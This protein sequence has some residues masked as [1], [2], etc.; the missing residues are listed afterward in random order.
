MTQDEIIRM[1]REAGFELGTA[2]YGNS[3]TL[4][5]FFNLAFEAGAA[6]ERE[7]P[8]T[9]P[10]NGLLAQEPSRSSPTDSQS[11]EIVP[12]GYVDAMFQFQTCQEHHVSPSDRF[13]PVYTAEQ[14][15]AAVLAEREACAK[16]CEN[17]PTPKD[18][19]TLTHIPTLETCAAAIR[20][21]GTHG[22]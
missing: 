6:H 19:T 3:K 13:K 22:D 11:N 15:E 20:A 10:A 1:A 21:R 17:L 2:W 16:V 14:I 9:V 12:V 5:R 7:K 4:E 8:V 18:A